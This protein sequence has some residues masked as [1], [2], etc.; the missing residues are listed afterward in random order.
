MME[1]ELLFGNP[2]YT[3]EKKDL[4][5]IDATSIRT[6]RMQLGLTQNAFAIA[7]GVSKKAVEKWEQ[8]SN[9]ISEP[10]KKLVYL[11]DKYPF[12]R[13]ELF[14]Y[15]MTTHISVGYPNNDK[16]ASQS[17]AS[18]TISEEAKK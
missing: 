17:I 2:T 10:I 8:G 16:Q 18:L 11:L 12:V 15:G 14:A 5:Y 13:E 4:S 6:I 7:V 9:A 3:Y 1:R